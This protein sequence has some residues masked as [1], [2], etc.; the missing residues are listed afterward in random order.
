MEN[1]PYVYPGNRTEG[2]KLIPQMQEF[3]A[4]FNACCNGN[5]EVDEVVLGKWFDFY[6]NQ[7]EKR[8]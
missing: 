5:R 8:E 1:E 2:K 3:S 4:L 6:M 7:K